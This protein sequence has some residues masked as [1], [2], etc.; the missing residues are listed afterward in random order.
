MRFPVNT[1][2]SADQVGAPASHAVRQR[3]RRKAFF[4][5]LGM[6]LV[7]FLSLVLLVIASG[8]TSS[9]ALTLAGAI[10]MPTFKGLFPAF[11][12]MKTVHVGD[13]YASHQIS[14]FDPPGALLATVIQWVLLAW[15]FARLVPA[16]TTARLVKA[17]FLTMVAVALATGTLVHGNALHF[18]PP[19]FSNCARAV[20]SSMETPQK[21]LL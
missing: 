20:T 16:H 11:F 14:M 4:T 3:H 21:A 1:K 15:L 18:K 17:A 5:M 2:P 9:A 10:T 6:P 7:T 8:L 19:G 13:L 12:L